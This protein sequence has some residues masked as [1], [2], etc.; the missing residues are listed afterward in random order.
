MN[1]LLEKE[2]IDLSLTH[3]K[4]ERAISYAKVKTDNVDAMTLA[5]LL[6]VGMIPEAHKISS[7]LRD[8]RDT[9]RSRL[10]LVE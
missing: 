9:L 2:G 10:H 3:A 8:I 7:D 6:R 1:D 4:F 5:Q